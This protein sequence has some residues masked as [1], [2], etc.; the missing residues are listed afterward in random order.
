[1]GAEFDGLEAHMT[2]AAARATTAIGT[3]SSPSSG[4]LLLHFTARD[5]YRAARQ[6]MVAMALGSR[7]PAAIMSCRS[8]REAASA[9]RP[10]AMIAGEGSAGQKAV[11]HSR[12]RSS[13]T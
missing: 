6:A 4:W 8:H 7:H 10:D 3:T 2:P 9:C 1:M 11:R 12:E 5:V 13:A